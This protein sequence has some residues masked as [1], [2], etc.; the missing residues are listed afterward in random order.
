MAFY[1]T[2]QSVQQYKKTQKSVKQNFHWLRG[3]MPIKGLWVSG[4]TTVIYKHKMIIFGGY[5]SPGLLEFDITRKKWRMITYSQSNQ[6]LTN[7]QFSIHINHHSAIVYNNLMI[8]FGGSDNLTNL[9]Q[10]ATL[11]LNLDTYKW[12]KIKPSG[13]IPSRRCAHSAVLTD[14]DR[15]IVFGGQESGSL[16][17]DTFELYLKTWK[18]KMIFT[19]GDLPTPRCCHS[20]IYKNSKMYIFGGDQHVVFHTLCNDLYELN[21]CKW[22]RIETI[23]DIPSKRFC[24]TTV[25]YGLDRMLLF[26]GETEKQISNELFVYHFGQRRWEKIIKFSGDL[27]KIS[28]HHSACICG[29]EMFIVGQVD[30]QFGI[31]KLEIG[32]HFVSSCNLWENILKKHFIDIVFNLSN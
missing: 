15:M 4:H 7:H 18:W 25:N 20:A 12:S 9:K 19:N 30:N 17:N 27:P 3:R 8:I 32:E 1:Y 31:Y 11:V 10:N 22:T 2:K 29:R 5:N 6:K 14:D 28:D 26:G 21:D 24:H 23:G 13:F 16:C